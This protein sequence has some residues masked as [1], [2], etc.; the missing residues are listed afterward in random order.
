MSLTI[1][2][3]KKLVQEKKKTFV[4]ELVKSLFVWHVTHGFTEVHRIKVSEINQIILDNY[5]IKVSKVYLKKG[6]EFHGYRRVVEQGRTYY[7]SIDRREMSDFEKRKELFISK[8]LKE[9]HNG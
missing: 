2:L 7:I 1:D 8:W 6:L 4:C 3:Y 5:G 9:T